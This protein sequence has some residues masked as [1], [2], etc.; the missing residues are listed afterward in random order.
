MSTPLDQGA[1]APP[2]VV[3]AHRGAS[4][5]APEHTFAAWD[6]ALALG[7]DYLEQDL[8]V[9]ADGVL[10]VLHDATLDRTTR[11]PGC[12]GPVRERTLDAIR[13]CDAGSW[14]NERF[15]D[16]ADPDFTR[17][18]VPTLEAV[19]TRYAPVGARFYI[20]TKD[21]GDAPG[22]ERELVRLLALH[23]LVPAP[24]STDAVPPAGARGGRLPRPLPRVVLQSFAA[25]SLRLLHELAPGVP[26]VQLLEPMEPESVIERLGG[27]ARYAAGIG[28][29]DTSVNADVVRAAA[30]HGLV[31]HPYTVNEIDAMRRLL[32]A[33][34]DGM[35]TDFP[36]RLLAQR[37]ERGRG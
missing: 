37:A 1:P 32:D 22:M 19:L 21:P 20:E 18:R 14:F 23:G 12:T 11:G 16:R 36:H 29:H 8:R 10:V 2:C 5:H 35:F 17:E 34:V 4:G 9:T 25:E 15:P 33:G 24:G 6:R 7:A 13:H 28:P 30:R 27:V 26:L 31:V 3:I